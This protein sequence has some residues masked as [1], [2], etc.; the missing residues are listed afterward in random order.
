MDRK[1]PK[2]CPK[3]LEFIE[4]TTRLWGVLSM[5]VMWGVG[6]DLT[7][8]KHSLGSYVL[9]I[10]VVL[11]ILE[12]S[13]AINLYLDLIIKDEKNVCYQCWQHIQWFDLWKKTILYLILSIFC[14]LRPSKM[15]LATIGG[16]MLIIL[17]LLYL[18]FA[19]K[20]Y[21]TERENMLY[22]KDCSYDRFEDLQDEIDDSLP[23][24]P[25]N[26][27]GDQDTILRV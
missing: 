9:F 20:M 25:S 23:E 1:K 15:W 27:V 17:A 6:T 13:F 14:F 5:I 26:N 19:Y 21:L 7:L 22:D 10:A 8:H 4:A 2:L 12:T 11:T 18:V 16:S 3:A 24:L